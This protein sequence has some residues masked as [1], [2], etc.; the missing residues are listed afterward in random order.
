M[1]Q[2]LQTT[3]LLHPIKA[4]RV[5]ILQ[6]FRW[7]GATGFLWAIVNQEVTGGEILNR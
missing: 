6:Q 2:K 7:Q 1:G 4:E 5:M 3:V